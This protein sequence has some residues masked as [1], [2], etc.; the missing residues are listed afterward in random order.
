MIEYLQLEGIGT[1][2]D[3]SVATLEDLTRINFLYGAN[4]SGKTTIGKV[5][6]RASNW[7]D[8]TVRWQE[9]TVR[10]VLVYNEDYVR[11]KIRETHLAG[12][13][14]IGENAREKEEA[15]ATKK[16]ELAQ[17]A[18]NR[19]KHDNFRQAQQQEKIT[20]TETFK[21]HCWNE[22]LRIEEENGFHEAFGGGRKIKDRL[23][24][25]VKESFLTPQETQDLAALRI[26]AETIYGDSLE[27]QLP[28]SL[29]PLGPLEVLEQSTV[30]SQPIIGKGDVPIA[31]LIHQLG[32]N[33]W[34]DQGRDYLEIAEDKCPFCQQSLAVGELQAQLE[35]FFDATFKHKKAALDAH[36][37]DWMRQTE[38]LD[39]GYQTL[40][41]SNHPQID[42]S[43]VEEHYR[44]YTATADLIVTKLKGKMSSPATVVEMPSLTSVIQQTNE[45]LI[46]ANQKVESHNETIANLDKEKNTLRDNIWHHFRNNLSL[47]FTAYEA[48]L[49]NCT[50]HISRKDAAIAEVDQKS[51]ILEEEVFQLEKDVTSTSPTIKAINKILKEFHFTTFYLAEAEEREGYYKIVRPGGNPAQNTLSEGEK[52]F[53]TFL[54]FYF[55]VRGGVDGAAGTDPR[56]VV[57]DDPISSLDSDILS[58][59]STLIRSLI[60][61]IID[62]DAQVQQLFLLTHNVYF[63]K[64]VTFKFE[65]VLEKKNKN[66]SFWIVRR[67]GMTSSVERH[68]TNPVQSSYEMLWASFR[69]DQGAIGVQNTMRKILENYFKVMG[70]IPLDTLMRKFEGNQKHICRSLL[71]WLHDG[72]HNVLDDLYTAP[73]QTQIEVYKEVFRMVFVHLNHEGHYNMMMKIA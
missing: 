18:D 7:T 52:T 43:A 59:V 58:I 37:I 35:A 66:V 11:D 51:K 20:L 53:L 33:D 9:D 54:Y 62:G 69:E 68:L 6:E 57:F 8:C 26:K 27:P 15:I 41:K 60:K 1:Y 65:E 23:L 56:I 2:R 14:T 10:K 50:G 16:A 44:T 4:G 70:G 12:V 63:H 40:L 72:S 39:A 48:A 34:V 73:N 17:L 21:D 61:D 30:P 55:S 28:I 49:A 38:K 64:E 25:M 67:D 29:L 13:F 5:I 19:Q 71:S 32:S 31:A 47:K 42:L 3:K 45:L 24:D 22:R 46:A 36:L